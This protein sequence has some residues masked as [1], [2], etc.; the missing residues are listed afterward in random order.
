LIPLV[1]LNG[2]DG[3]EGPI[4]TTSPKAVAREIN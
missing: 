3:P 2:V 4:T 1:V